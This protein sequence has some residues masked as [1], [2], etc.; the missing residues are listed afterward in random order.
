[1]NSALSDDI[2][3]FNPQSG[4]I[5]RLQPG[6]SLPSD[7]LV[8]GYIVSYDASQKSVCG[9]VLGGYIAH[10]AL[11]AWQAAR[12]YPTAR[13]ELVGPQQRCKICFDSNASSLIDS[14]QA[15][16]DPARFS[17][18]SG[19]MAAI[20]G[21]IVGKPFT[22]PQ[23]V[24]LLVSDGIV[25]AQRTDKIGHE[26]IGSKT[27]FDKNWNNLIAVAGLSKSEHAAL[28][29]RMAVCLSRS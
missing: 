18:M 7:Q 6:I 8:K 11:A 13:V 24:D 9:R 14:L 15:K 22:D 5:H 3:Y 21:Y 10:R 1:M 23:I 28:K 20:V 29:R 26:F 4:T 12:T 16:L 25:L 27:D 19:K 17:D 2:E